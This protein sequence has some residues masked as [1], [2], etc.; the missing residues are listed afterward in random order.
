[1][2]LCKWRFLSKKMLTEVMKKFYGCGKPLPLGI[3]GLCPRPR[4][5]CGVP[6]GGVRRCCVVRRAPPHRR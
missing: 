3:D 2:K 1:M 5:S 4:A 6:H